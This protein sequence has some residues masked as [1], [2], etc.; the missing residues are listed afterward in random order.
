[1]NQEET[2]FTQNLPVISQVPYSLRVREGFFK[3]FDNS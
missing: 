3:G 1:M 2:E